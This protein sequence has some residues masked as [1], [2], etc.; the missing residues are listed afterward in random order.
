M[1][2]DY[3]QPLTQGQRDQM[4][5]AR[6]AMYD[7]E[8]QQ[9]LDSLKESNDEMKAE[10]ENRKLAEEA[11]KQAEKAEKANVEAQ[12]SAL[13]IGNDMLLQNAAQTEEEQE[14]DQVAAETEKINPERGFI[15]E[16]GEGIQDFALNPTAY[17]LDKATGGA[18]PSY[19]RQAKSPGGVLSD[20]REAMRDAAVEKGGASGFLA[21]LEENTMA[22][23][24]GS[25]A[26][27]N[28]FP[29]PVT[30]AGR[31]LNQDT[32]SWSDPPEQLKGNPFGEGLYEL[33]Q[34][35]T[36]SLFG[37]GI[38]AYLPA[39]PALA[40]RI[41][42][43]A[44]EAQTIDSADEILFGEDL[45]ASVAKLADQIYPG[46]GAQVAKDL[47]E[48]RGFASQAFI[49]TVGTFQSVIGGAAIERF[50]FWANRN[51]I[52]RPSVRRAAEAGAGKG[53]PKVIDMELANTIDATPSRD[54]EPWST[55][56]SNR[57]VPVARSKG[58]INSDALA[59][60]IIRGTGL[61]DEYITGAQNSYYVNWNALN[62][63]QYLLKQY[64]ATSLEL[65]NLKPRSHD[66]AVAI[67]DANNW[68]QDHAAFLM[69]NNL[70]PWL[71]SDFEDMVLAYRQ[72][73][74]TEIK[75]R[76]YDTGVIVNPL[77]K[78]LADQ[79]LAYEDLSFYEKAGLTMKYAGKNTGIGMTIGPVIMRK[80]GIRM[81]KQAQVVSNLIQ[82]NMT[83][84]DAVDVYMD[85]LD[86]MSLFMA[87]D[88]RA[89]RDTGFDML[90]LQKK[91]LDYAEKGAAPRLQYI[92]G[93]ELLPYKL[94]EEYDLWMR[95]ASGEPLTLR[96]WYQKS[97][98]DPGK[99]KQGFEQMMHMLAAT[100]PE[101]LINAQEVSMKAVQ[102]QLLKGN[103]VAATQL[104]YSMMLSRV[105][106]QTVAA[107]STLIQLVNE[108]LGG[109]LRG[110]GSREFQYGLGQFMGGIQGF[111]QALGTGVR[112]LR[113][114]MPINGGDRIEALENLQSLADRQQT[115]ELQFEQIRRMI[116]NP[117][118]AGEVAELTNAT[119]SFIL[120]SIANNPV[121]NAGQR[122]LMSQD[123]AA[124]IVKAY[125]DAYGHAALRAMDEGGD[126]KKYA[127][128]NLA[129]MFIKG[130]NG[131]ITDQLDLNNLMARG[132]FESAQDITFQSKIPE[133]GSDG[134]ENKAEPTQLFRVMQNAAKQYPPFQMFVPFTKIAY[135]MTKKPY[136]MF[137]GFSQIQGAKGK[138]F[139]MDMGPISKRYYDILNAPEY[140]SEGNFQ[141]QVV[142]AKMQAKSNAMQGV[143]FTMG[144]LALA[145]LGLATSD[146][147]KTGPRASFV[148]PAPGTKT[149]YIAIDY[150]RVEPMGTILR[151]VTGFHEAFREGAISRGEY[152]QGIAEA[153][154]VVGLATLDR[155]ILQGIQNAQQIIDL[156]NFTVSGIPAL[157][158]TLASPFSPA[159]LRMA[160]NIMYP[161]QQFAFENDDLIG[162]VLR[163]LQGRISGGAGMFGNDPNYS[164]PN[165]M[166]GE[167]MLDVATMKKGQDYWSVVGGRLA[168]EFFPGKVLNYDVSP[169]EKKLYEDFG[170]SFGSQEAK[171]KFRRVGSVDLTIP[172]QQQ[173]ARAMYDTGLVNEQLRY[174]INQNQGFKKKVK[175]YK[176]A[177]KNESK[178]GPLDRFKNEDVN[179]SLQ[180]IRDDINRV[181][182]NAKR[183]A[184]QILMEQGELQDLKL[185]IEESKRPTVSQA[186][187]IGSPGTE[188]FK[189][190]Y[191]TAAEIA[192]QNPLQED[193]QTILDIA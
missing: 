21:G 131:E 140:D 175:D 137:P 83:Y 104:F 96:Q 53:D 129:S 188:D 74:I 111:Q 81:Q 18:F 28:T 63:K 170:W 87:P 22:L 171:R 25:A 112:T 4:G 143:A 2:D 119:M 192:A 77:D 158:N 182:N 139:G 106:T 73:L 67:I 45:V 179:E 32:N 187:P 110:K 40:E 159:A 168:N 64:Q 78:A 9:Y 189:G 150:T 103:G 107:A 5:P 50:M 109:M 185:R 31:L 125:Q 147:T 176:T 94:P 86:R 148:I 151:L 65:E 169:L 145:E 17:V 7:Q 84:G 75:P 35:L 79:G 124:I 98:E 138:V 47:K 113:Q 173:I 16:L 183:Q 152:A 100:P 56:D 71:K 180:K 43:G 121:I 41:A 95:D 108:P 6:A 58:G 174:L 178:L 144:A 157:I 93:D 51:F 19:M 184:I 69:N 146:I 105:S 122:F 46:Q 114:G 126:M 34:M 97:L 166:T 135:H 49:N 36:P 115:L 132:S 1:N 10:A 30:L 24:Q 118:T 37:A 156:S 68:M 160:G 161:A 141:P 149:G 57:Y 12:M 62:S 54:F 191:Q 134:R 61:T 101:I 190:L 48:G 193:V 82:S 14:I 172:E 164:V 102:K 89:R 120:Q 136:R 123:Q 52:S 127:T 186:A 165:P 13:S 15:T 3:S 44:L 90:R 42:E 72:D 153:A 66:Q 167:T 39:M 85:L 177:R 27:F 117:K 142:T 181:F 116:G 88:R 92:E 162:N 23:A 60:D 76:D 99:Y 29:L 70:E 154:Q 8:R 128:E 155:N 38:R 133:F 33:G 91:M 26:G 130:A 59:T 11:N 163:N 20:E 55:T 80:L